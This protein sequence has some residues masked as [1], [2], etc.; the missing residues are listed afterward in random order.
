MASEAIDPQSIPG[1]R[2]SAEDAFARGL[3]CAESVVAAIA[4]AQGVD[5]VPLQKAATAFCSGVARTSGVCGALNGA[6]M[7]VSLALGRSNPGESVQPAYEAAQR[8]IREFAGEFGGTNCQTL[9]SGC[10]LNT[11]EGQARFKEQRLGQ[12]CHRY[13]GAAAEMAARIIADV[14]DGQAHR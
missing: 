9:L 7:G 11:P 14:A 13:T 1:I 4:T 2:K 10:D 3:F 6:I 5:P 12:R 8:L